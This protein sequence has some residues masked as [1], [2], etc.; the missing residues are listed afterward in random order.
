MREAL[1]KHIVCPRCRGEFALTARRRE[2][3]HVMEGSLRCEGCGAAYPIDAGIPVLFEQRLVNADNTRTADRF[4]YE[5]ERFDFLSSTYEPQ[6]LDWVWPITREFF[7]GKVV[8]D[9]GCGKGRHAVCSTRFGASEVIGIDLA[10][11]SVSAAFRNTRELEN[12]HIVRADIFNLPFR[13]EAFDYIYSIGV[14]HH[15]PDPGRAFSCLAGKL[16]RRGTISIWV[17]GKEGNW[18]ITSLLN[19]IRLAITSRLPLVVTRAI[20]FVLA[21]ALQLA[22][23]S[24]Y[25]PVNQV[26]WLKPL[27]R[28]LFYNDYLYY[29]SGFSFRE[30]YSIVFDHLL[31]E[32]A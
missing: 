10:A 5:W 8:L 24:V 12:V 26:S 30:N 27:S 2:N 25:R 13:D 1:L 29:I 11:G 28:F 17:Y 21:I 7:P 16:R 14:L 19:P 6:F 22:L 20:A 18:W 31:P 23:K 3:P 15:T 4:G 9:A 32:I